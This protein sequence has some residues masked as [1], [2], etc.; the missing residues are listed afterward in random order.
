MSD[1]PNDGPDGPPTGADDV[2][3]APGSALARRRA[4]AA[5]LDLGALRRDDPERWRLLHAAEALRV[6]PDLLAVT[7]PLLSALW[8]E[9]TFYDAPAGRWRRLLI[10]PP[11]TAR[12]LE[13]LDASAPQLATGQGE[14]AYYRVVEDRRGVR[15]ELGRPLE[16]AAWRPDGGVDAEALV[17]PFADEAAA[18]SWADATVM[19]AGDGSFTYDTVPQGGVWFADVFPGDPGG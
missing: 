1:G 17:G 8:P 6:T 2:R 9:A 15:R 3:D 7:A 11:R 18:R 14:H 12:D 19:G 5:G 16:P 4:A 13:R 10:Y